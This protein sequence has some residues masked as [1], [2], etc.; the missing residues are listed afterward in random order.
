MSGFMRKLLGYQQPP[1]STDE[2]TD[3][4]RFYTDAEYVLRFNRFLLDEALS[5]REQGTPL[6]PIIPH[7][8]ERGKEGQRMLVA[9][10]DCWQ[11]SMND[12][13]TPRPDTI[14]P[15]PEGISLLEAERIARDR[16]PGEGSMQI[17]VVEQISRALAGAEGQ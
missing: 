15:I 7:C 13:G 14:S 3:L 10:R 16:E 12:I 2:D 5:G 17:G 4:E 6:R 9:L 11:S 1:Q 8:L